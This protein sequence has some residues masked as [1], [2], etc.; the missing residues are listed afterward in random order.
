MGPVDTPTG[1][2]LRPF[3]SHL[4]PVK[5]QSGRRGCTM[6]SRGEVARYYPEDEQYLVE[7]EPN[8]TH[9]EVVVGQEILG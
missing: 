5:I 2:R 1:T 8:V 7:M 4:D 9:F 6:L 3:V